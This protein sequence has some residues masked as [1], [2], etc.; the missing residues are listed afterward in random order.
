MAPVTADSWI[1][2]ARSRG[3][4]DWSTYVDR[5]SRD[6]ALLTAEVLQPFHP[7]WDMRVIDSD[8]REV[9]QLDTTGKPYPTDETH[10][11]RGWE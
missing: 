8:T 11:E 6:D 4:A 9:I 5:L 7:T 10:L 3:F 2:E 1:V